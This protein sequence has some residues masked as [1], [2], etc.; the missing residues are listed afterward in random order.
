MRVSPTSQNCHQH[1]WSPTSVTN[2]TTSFFYFGAIMGLRVFG[3]RADVGGQHCP[4]PVRV[5]F[6]SGF[7]GK[8]CPVSVWC[9]DSVQIFC[10]MSVCPDFFCLDSVRCPDLKKTVR[11]LSVRSAGQGRDRAVRTFAVL[12]RRHLFL[13]LYN[14]SYSELFYNVS[15]SEFENPKNPRI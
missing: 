12:V 11:C 9:P 13:K 1:I 5:L 7:S 14:L 2:I 8:S 6:L 15:Y 4:C 3:L 10:P